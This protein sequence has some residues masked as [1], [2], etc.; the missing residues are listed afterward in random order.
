MHSH[1][2]GGERISTPADKK[3]H[4]ADADEVEEMLKFTEKLKEDEIIDE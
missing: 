4:S 3:G 1:A 2:W